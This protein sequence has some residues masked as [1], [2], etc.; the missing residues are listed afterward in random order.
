M[1][2]SRSLKQIIIGLV[3]GF[4]AVL[5]IGWWQYMNQKPE[6]CNDNLK[7][8]DELGIDCGGVCGV[9]SDM[10]L[11]G[12]AERPIVQS[13]Q[14]VGNTGLIELAITVTNPNRSVGMS[15]LLLTGEVK[16]QDGNTRSW[17][18]TTYLRPS[19]TK[20][21]LVNIYNTAPLQDAGTATVGDVEFAT[22]PTTALGVAPILR[23]KKL[24]QDGDTVVVEGLVANTSALTIGTLYIKILLVD[25]E[26][27]LVSTNQ[28]ELRNL[29]ARGERD[30]RLEWKV[31]TTKPLSATFEL[32]TNVFDPRN[33]QKPEGAPALP[34]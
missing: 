5:I 8:Q 34:F 30:F 23:S 25:S 27:K 7:N 21:V 26:G 13:V 2:L 16:L 32:D 14:S 9:C 19:E 17:R 6:T 10:S 29:V 18:T 3:Y 4:I 33:I 11:S 28:T 20:L 15:N 12:E 24:S 31:E 1:K 22:V